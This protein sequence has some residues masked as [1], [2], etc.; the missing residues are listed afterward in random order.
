MQKNNFKKKWVSVFITASF[1]LFL[2]FFSFVNSSNIDNV[3]GYAW[4]GSWMD[5]LPYNN[6]QDFP[7]E[8]TGGVGFLSFNCKDNNSCASSSYGV[9]INPDTGIISGYAWSPNYGWLKFGG[10]SDF[11][12]GSGTVS[13]N[14]KLDLSTGIVTGWARFCSVASNTNTCLGFA[15]NNTSNGGWDGWVSLNGKDYK[16]SFDKETKK[17][18]GYAWG[19]DIVGWINFSDLKIPYSVSYDPITVPVVSLSSNSYS[20]PKNSKVTLSWTG[21]NLVNS[22]EGCVIANSLNSDKIK[23][24][25]PSGTFTTSSLIQNITYTINCDGLTAGT[26]ANSNVSIGVNIPSITFYATPGSVASLPSTVTLNWNS[27]VSIKSCVA[28]SSNN[29]STIQGW[30]GNLSDSISSKKVDVLYNPTRYDLYCFNTV[31]GSKI[32]ANPVFV[33]SGIKNPNDTTP[34]PGDP[35]YVEPGQGLSP[36]IKIKTD[37]AAN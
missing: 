3:S 19:S 37:G 32:D 1:L 16:V 26:T 33:S 22:A 7:N 14:A 36:N 35:K 29:A 17:I 12:I 30:N 15:G 23:V 5:L 27:N 31:D 4:G 11:P 10:L 6:T 9:N 25:S 8:E 20:V 28:S 18:N 24:P 13:E 34:K 21:L 2:G